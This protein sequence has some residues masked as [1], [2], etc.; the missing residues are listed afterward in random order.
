MFTSDG[1]E[2]MFYDGQFTVENMFDSDGNEV[3]NASWSE[4]DY[5]TYNADA[6]ITAL[7]QAEL[8]RTIIVSAVATLYARK[9]AR[10]EPEETD[11][12]FEWGD[13]SDLEEVS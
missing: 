11:E 13:S 8:E 1:E 4:P 6:F 10:D 5:E 7:E 2:I 12:G 3:E 9:R